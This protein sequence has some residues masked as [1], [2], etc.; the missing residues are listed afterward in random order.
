MI[1]FRL[2]FPLFTLLPANDKTNYLLTT[3]QTRASSFLADLAIWG[4]KETK[5]VLSTLLTIVK[6]QQLP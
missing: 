5:S 3:K 6:V 1:L 4:C 2:L